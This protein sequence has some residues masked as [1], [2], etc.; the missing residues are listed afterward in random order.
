MAQMNGEDFEKK[1][2]EWLRVRVLSVLAGNSKCGSLTG[3][4]GGAI[5]A[6]CGRP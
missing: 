5:H 2:G 4:S 1:F 3:P 6:G